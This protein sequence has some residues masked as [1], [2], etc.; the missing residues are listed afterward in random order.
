MT[1]FATVEDYETRYGEV[2]DE[3]R[4]S[5]LLQDATN[6]I[7]SQPGFA[8]R[9]DETWQGVLET[10]TCAMVHRSMMS[11]A[12]AGLSNVSQGAGGYT[13]SVSVYNPGGDLYLTRNERRVLG[14]GGGRIGQTD[15]YGCDAR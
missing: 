12:Y 1:P 2:E 3:A 8:M 10:V 13:A 6:I 11:G 5:A 15:P 4:V 9:E 14:L 7:A